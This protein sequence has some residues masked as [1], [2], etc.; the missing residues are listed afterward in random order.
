LVVNFLVLYFA[1]NWLL[2]KPLAKLFRERE[3]A[4]RGAMDEAKALTR[5]KDD[6]VSAMNAGIAEAR[7][8]AKTAREKLREEGVSIQKDSVAGA[9]SEAVAMIE[10]ARTELRAEIVRVRAAM[11]SDVEQL[12]EDIVRKLVKV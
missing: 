5:K 2:F 7:S 6:A 3:S 1:L 4:T 10:E 11:Q 8:N 9:E 12:S